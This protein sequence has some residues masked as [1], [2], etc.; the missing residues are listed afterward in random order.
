MV[1]DAGGARCPVCGGFD[2]VARRMPLFI[3]T[4]ASG[5]GK[6]TLFPLLL[7]RLSSR[8]I[9]FDVD[10]LIDPMKSA[11]RREDVEWEA[12]RDAWLTVAHGVAQNGM[13]TVL[14]SPFHPGQLDELPGRAWVGDIHFL[15][16]D[17]PDRER[18]RRIRARP[19]WRARDIE[20][21]NEFGR[22]LRDHVS[23][24][25]DTEKLS[26]QATADAVTQWIAKSL[27]R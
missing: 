16:L 14:L 7:E 6:S 2:P 3:V 23:P 5:A 11:G 8:C 15:A 1:P 21:Q 26:P 20:Q 4:G 17:C 18:E 9:V 12:F 19:S 22:W 24:V 25:V 10:W 13:P 27:G